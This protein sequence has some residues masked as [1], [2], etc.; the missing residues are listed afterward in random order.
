MG[1]GAITEAVAGVT[2]LTQ[3][4]ANAYTLVN[5]FKAV[6]GLVTYGGG[7]WIIP[8]DP[9]TS[10]EG[11]YVVYYELGQIEYTEGEA[12][13][14]S[15]IEIYYLQ[16]NGLTGYTSS[17]FTDAVEKVY[18]G[19]GAE[20]TL[21]SALANAGVYTIKLLIGEVV[22][23]QAQFEVKENGN[24]TIVKELKGSDIAES[25]IPRVTPY[26]DGLFTLYGK[27]D[28][29]T[30]SVSDCNVTDG[31]NTYTK[32]IKLTGGKAV[33]SV[34]EAELANL[35]KIVADKAGTIR[36][37]VSQKNLQS[38]SLD[39]YLRLFGADAMEISTSTVLSGTDALTM[40]IVTFEISEAGTYFI[41]TN[42]NGF[43]LYSVAW[44]TQ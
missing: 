9:A 27:I 32:T 35:I 41:G 17:L 6:N 3:E 44:I 16:G 19:S 28:N 24:I 38:S 30:I 33:A 13:V 12:F 43:Q 39:V 25:S 20:V 21:E 4:E 26:L 29:L 1:V 31:T 34:N 7:D 2:I 23:A 14:P 40:S 11:I 8:T 15:D 37:V 18:D 42:S 5:I 22:Y 36:L 10:V